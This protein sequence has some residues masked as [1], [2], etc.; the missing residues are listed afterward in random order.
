MEKQAIPEVV[1][2]RLPIYLQILNH[3]Q[4]EGYEIVSSKELAKHLGVTA[5]QIR[6]D[7]SYFG[8]FGKQGSGYN[9]TRL[10]DEL[11]EILNLNQIW[12]V[13]LVGVGNLGQALLSYQGFSRKGF[14]LILAFDN[15]PKLINTTISGLKVL[16][17]ENLEEEINKCQVKIAILT[18][19]SQVAQDITNRLVNCGIKAILNYA[20]ITLKVDSNIRVLNIDP[21]LKLQNLSYYLSEQ[22]GQ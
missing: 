13:A 14:E 20:P 6:K 16:D 1:I 7:F 2:A 8:E 17:V 10:T 9:V 5:A 12:Q 18:V 19:P 4:R 3:L 15:N 22:V 11:R 21:V